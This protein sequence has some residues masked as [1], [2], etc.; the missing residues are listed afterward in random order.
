MADELGAALEAWSRREDETTLARVHAALL[1]ATV[2]L[3]VRT[4]ALAEGP[5]AR[6][7]LPSER[8]AELSLLTVTLADGRR[9]LPVFTGTDDLRRWRIE[10]RPVQASMR[11][12]CRAALDEGWSGLVVDVATHGFVVG[13]AV[14][15][16]LAEGALPVLG[17]G[18]TPGG[19][20]EMVALL[21]RA[22]A[23]E[24]AVSAAW[25]LETDP[26]TVALQLKVPLDAQGLSTITQR[27]NRRLVTA[28]DAILRVSVVD[29]IDPPA[30]TPLWP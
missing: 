3:P 12:A 24:P 11:S 5:A 10:A 20:Q 2:L 30:G 6:T 13:P 18:A 15:A 8:E 21:R 1:D 25:L 9:V 14:V 29:G 16:A 27:L 17:P 7:G 4:V 23:R 28:G 19:R 26:P 22:V